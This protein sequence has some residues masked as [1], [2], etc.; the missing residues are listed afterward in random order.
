MAPIA[1]GPNARQSCSFVSSFSAKRRGSEPP[2]PTRVRTRRNPKQTPPLET[3]FFGR[4]LSASFERKR[5]TKP[6]YCYRRP[7]SA[8]LTL[9]NVGRSWNR[10]NRRRSC[11]LPGGAEGIQ[12]DGHRELTPSGRGIRQNLSGGRFGHPSVQYDALREQILDVTKAGGEPE[13]EPDRLVN[14]LRREPISG[15][16]DYRRALRLAF[17]AP[18]SCQRRDNAPLEAPRRDRA[19][20]A[21]S[22][23]VTSPASKSSVGTVSLMDLEWGG[24]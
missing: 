2:L 11:G 8:T 24:G 5:Q 14:D 15:V 9:S 23:T 6:Q 7:Y 18:A 13:I 17:N 12:T 16:A 19:S 3:E 10:G 21:M 4:R 1:P 20:F 22:L